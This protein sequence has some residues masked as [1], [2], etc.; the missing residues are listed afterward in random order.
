[1]P[2]EVS[3]LEGPVKCLTFLGIEVDTAAL[4]LRLP[5]DKLDD[6]KRQLKWAT[7]RQSVPKEKL[8]SLVGLLQFAT[9][10]VR[11]GRPFL[12]RLYA[13]KH[14]GSQLDHL[15]RLSLPADADILWWYSISLWIPGMESHS[16]GILD[17]KHQMSV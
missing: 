6:L 4:Q 5:K 9:K 11:P 17:F 14:V 10:V 13:L 3:K 15:V 2:L 16:Y 7:F 1:M 8:E 12:R